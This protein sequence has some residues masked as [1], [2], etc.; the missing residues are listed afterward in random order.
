MKAIVLI[1]IVAVLAS[2][3]A[4]AAEGV[5]VLFV[6]DTSGSMT[7]QMQAVASAQA[8]QVKLAARPGD[9]VGRIVF[10]DYS[11]KDLLAEIRTGADVVNAA[12]VLASAPSSIS[13]WT[14]ISH[15]L[16]SAFDLWKARAGGRRTLVF[17]V[18]D[19]IPATPPASLSAEVE[20]L[21]AQSVRWKSAPG[22]KIFLVAIGR[23]DNAQAIKRL[24]E[25]LGAQVVTPD[26]LASTNMIAR[27]LREAR[28]ITSTAQKPRSRGKNAYLPLAAIAAGLLAACIVIGRVY[29]RPK[30][31]ANPNEF[32]EEGPEDDTWTGIVRVVA[33]VDGEP[34]V[35]RLFMPNDDCPEGRVSFGP[36]GCHI[37]LP[38]AQFNLALSSSA[39]AVELPVGE[40]VTVNGIIRTGGEFAIGESSEI[41]AGSA[42]VI[43]DLK[44]GRN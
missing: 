6:L 5:F 27:E 1:V 10:S 44:K 43:I 15:G 16:T 21:K 22:C 3:S 34:E 26:A 32:S 12:E 36:F 18:T 17:L 14:Y 24:S 7:K 29:V 42:H 30:N 39:T 9:F 28:P 37:S 25:Q 33:T 8:A 13:G 11:R 38:D 4:A 19:G 2:A 35:I 20:A 23:P 40:S 41:I 31:R